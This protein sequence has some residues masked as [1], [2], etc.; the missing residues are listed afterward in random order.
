MEQ[1]NRSSKKQNSE[2]NIFHAEK[3]NPITNPIQIN[4]KNPYILKMLAQHNV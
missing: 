4:Y 2:A 3:Y 1:S